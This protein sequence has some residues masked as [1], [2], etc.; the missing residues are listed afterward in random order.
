MQVWQCHNS[1]GHQ[2]YPIICEKVVLS[3]L[4]TVQ[5]LNKATYNYFLHDKG[6]RNLYNWVVKEEYKLNS[7]LITLIFETVSSSI[8][9]FQWI[10]N[11]F[12]VQ[13]LQFNISIRK[14]QMTLQYT[15]SFQEM[16]KIPEIL[17][18]GTKWISF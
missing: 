13:Y 16:F 3:F 1:C 7:T 5:F 11:T 4:K 9:R 12:K 18:L 8:C 2:W 6:K 14:Y 17:L 10:E 15:I